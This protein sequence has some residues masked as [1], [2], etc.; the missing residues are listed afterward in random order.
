[1]KIAVTGCNGSVGR[2]VVLNALKQGHNV[3]GI[4]RAPLPTE[5][6][7]A[8]IGDASFLCL[9]VD[10]RDFDATMAALR[11]CEGV[12]HLAAHR[13]PTDYLVKSH[14]DNVVMSWNVLRACAELGIKR[15]A[16]ASSV[17]VLPM[18][19]SIK[20]NFD[21]FPIDEEHPCRPDEPYGLSKIIGEQQADTIVRRY[22][23]T[24]IASLRLHWSIPDPSE[25]DKGFRANPDRQSKDLWSWV[26]EDAAA[27]AFLRSLTI[28]TDAWAGH[29]RF[30]VVAPTIAPTGVDVQELKQK[31]YPEVTVR[32]GFELKGRAGF[33]DCRKAEKLLGWV[34]PI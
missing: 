21:Y 8:I 17:N 6:S 15:I 23:S 2:R 16:M 18:V 12:V 26:Q 7:A 31:Y 32:D 34:H 3:F 11:G 27:D 20:P 25:A 4:D 10:C 14:N 1:M 19:F 9:V 13:D 30:F 33:F 22:P 5:D 28:E 24:R 29:E